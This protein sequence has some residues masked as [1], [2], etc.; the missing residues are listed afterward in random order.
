MERKILETIGLGTQGMTT[1]LLH[2]PAL[3]FHV[4]PVF[5]TYFTRVLKGRLRSIPY[6]FYGCWYYL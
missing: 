3:G 5:S 6:Y 2:F 4:N 1:N